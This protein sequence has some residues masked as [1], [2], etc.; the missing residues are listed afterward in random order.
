MAPVLGR[1][2]PFLIYGY[3]AALSLG[4]VLGVGLT[5]MLARRLAWAR[6]SLPWLDAALVALAAAL[7]GGR[8]GFVLQAWDYYQARPGQIWE[9]WQGG[10]TYPG[11]LL[12]GL[13]GVGVWLW[14]GKRPFWPTL[15]LLAPAV[16]VVNV[17]GWLACWLEGCAYGRETVLTGS[18]W[19]DW[20]AAD[21]PDT[22]GVFALR[23][24]TQLLGGLGA[25][26]VLLLLL[27]LLR[28]SSPVAL[29]AVAL[30]GI[31][32]ARLPLLPLRG[33]APSP[34]AGWLDVGVAA[35]G[36]LL[37]QWAWRRR[38]AAHHDEEG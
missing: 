21:L 13:L 18:P 11:A 28:R 25:L 24:Q 36:L 10:L 33:D 37:L 15:G 2:G 22:Y 4:F 32:L 26:L 34:A 19:R 8:A 23:F 35:A 5:A 20:L 29:T 6:P 27:W 16:A 17:S 1:V 38:P 9:V 30:L 31:S 12:G 3:T 7:A 14:V